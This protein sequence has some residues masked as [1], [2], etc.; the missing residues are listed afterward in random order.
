[1]RGCR[2]IKTKKAQK[3]VELLVFYFYSRY[4]TYVGLLCGS[5][6]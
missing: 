5:G 4:Y 3:Q 1:M 6:V 2:G